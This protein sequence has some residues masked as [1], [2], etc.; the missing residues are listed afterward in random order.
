M[1]SRDSNKIGEIPKRT[2]QAA[3]IGVRLKIRERAESD[4]QSADSDRGL[5]ELEDRRRVISRRQADFGSFTLE[6]HV[7]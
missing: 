5:C 1:Q 6:S 4:A 3:A 7:Q 2:E